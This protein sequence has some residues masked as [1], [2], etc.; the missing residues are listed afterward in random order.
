MLTKDVL[1]NQATAIPV[2]FGEGGVTVQVTLVQLRNRRGRCMVLY[3]C[4]MQTTGGIKSYCSSCFEAWIKD[5]LHA[6]NRGYLRYYSWAPT[7][8]YIYIYIY[9]YIYF[10]YIYIL[11]NYMVRCRV[12]ITMT[13]KVL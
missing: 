4:T 9:I 10:T 11:G 13:W 2:A 6:L 3:M 7:F 1:L 8:T 12:V 5:W